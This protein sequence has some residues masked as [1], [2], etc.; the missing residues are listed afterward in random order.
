MGQSRR[1]GQGDEEIRI[2]LKE[3]KEGKEGRKEGLF[4]AQVPHKKDEVGEIGNNTK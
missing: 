4:P 1:V 3:S 2:N